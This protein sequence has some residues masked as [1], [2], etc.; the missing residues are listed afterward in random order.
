L[1]YVQDGQRCFSREESAVPDQDIYN[2]ERVAAWS[3]L[4]EV[5]LSA[6]SNGT[7]CFL[8]LDPT[9]LNTPLNQEICIQ[10]GRGEFFECQRE[11]EPYYRPH[12]KFENGSLLFTQ[13]DLRV[14]LVPQSHGFSISKIERDGQEI[15]TEEGVAQAIKQ[16]DD[17]ALGASK[18]VKPN[19]DCLQAAFELEPPSP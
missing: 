19:P 11:G 7:V 1:F 13:G 6:I 12:A 3:G 4:P 2:V 17:T 10:E 5:V 16:L 9:R 14:T 8:D 18:L 15:K